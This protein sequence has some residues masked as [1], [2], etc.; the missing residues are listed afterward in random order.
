LE[1]VIGSVLGGLQIQIGGGRP[2][3]GRCHRKKFPHREGDDEGGER[4]GKSRLSHDLARTRGRAAGR[5]RRR[6][7][8]S[9]GA[10]VGDREEVPAISASEGGRE[11]GAEIREKGILRLCNPSGMEV[12]IAVTPLQ[13]A[14][15]PS[16][17]L[18]EYFAGYP[19]PLAT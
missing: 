15:K 19:A 4:E 18:R 8:C 7:G 16:G 12:D 14:G 13:P 6:L 11:G 10:C 3:G 17:V 1:E 9:G 5:G 2:L